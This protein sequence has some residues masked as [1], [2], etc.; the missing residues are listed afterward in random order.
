[1]CG[2]CVMKEMLGKQLLRLMSQKPKVSEHIGFMFA[3]VEN[4]YTSVAMAIEDGTFEMLDQDGEPIEASPE[5]V[6]PIVVSETI[7][8]AMYGLM[9]EDEVMRARTDTMMG[10]LALA[11]ATAIAWANED[12][13]LTPREAFE[14]WAGERLD[15]LS[16]E[17]DTEPREAARRVVREQVERS[18]SLL[19]EIDTSQDYL[20]TGNESKAALDPSDADVSDAVEKF[21]EG[22]E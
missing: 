15:R 12:E 3:T 11:F 17:D 8:T 9:S 1:M 19:D 2:I 6:E 20:F 16:S 7:M 4:A 5:L 10:N 18:R 13:E 21:L 14:Q 22:I